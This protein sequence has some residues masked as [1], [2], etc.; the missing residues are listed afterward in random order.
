[1]TGAAGDCIGPHRTTSWSAADTDVD[2]FTVDG[3][4]DVSAMQDVLVQYGV[5]IARGADLG[6]SPREATEAI[7]ALAKCFGPI[8]PQDQ[9]GALSLDVVDIGNTDGP[10]R[11]SYA[12]GVGNSHAVPLHTENDGEPVPP[13][14]VFFGCL[15]ASS[16]GGASILASGHHVHERMRRL[17]CAAFERLHG[18]FEFGR[19]PDDYDPS[20]TD[21]DHVFRCASGTTSVRYSR[22]WLNEAA[23]IHER[24][25]SPG[26]RR[27]LDRLDG[28][29]ADPTTALETMLGPG[30]ILAVDNR[31]VLHGRRAFEDGANRRHLTRVWVD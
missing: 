3:D 4:F 24:F 16:T 2:T 6:R 19:R 31:I 12:R 21:S 26:V 23:L 17:D 14:L 7:R 27:A 18:K 20:V 25:Q 11:A 29:L 10:A 15:S 28:I 1:M 8:H 30:D 13:R 22:Y 5:C 9:K